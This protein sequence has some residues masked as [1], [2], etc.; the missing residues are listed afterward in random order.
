[1]NQEKPKRVSL[2]FYLYPGQAE[3]LQ[4][5]YGLKSVSACFRQA[6]T[7]DSGLAL[8]DIDPNNSTASPASILV[9]K[10]NTEKGKPTT[11]TPLFEER[12]QTRKTVA[13]LL[14]VSRQAV[15]L[16][17]KSIKMDGLATRGKYLFKLSV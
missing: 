5:H 14:G 9:Y 1:M 7:N 3:V 12:P 10:I 2:N 8:P 6:L 4:R 13:E 17:V 15:H 16:L 11:T